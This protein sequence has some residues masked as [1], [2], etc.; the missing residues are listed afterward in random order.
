[1]DNMRLIDKLSQ[2]ILRNNNQ[3]NKEEISFVKM[4][5]FKSGL[6]EFVKNMDKD[7]KNNLGVSE[8]QRA[9]PILTSTDFVLPKVAHRCDVLV[10]MLLKIDN[11]LNNKLFQDIESGKRE[12]FKRIMDKYRDFTVATVEYFNCKRALAKYISNVMNIETKVKEL[13]RPE[14]TIEEWA[15]EYFD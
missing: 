13:D 12:E 2:G 8:Y 10:E 6:A 5:K 14:K 1:M 4:N 9:S 3:R 15:S 11:A 7:I